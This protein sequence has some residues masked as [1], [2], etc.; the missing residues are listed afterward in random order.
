MAIVK[1]TQLHGL[2][3]KSDYTCKSS[4]MCNNTHTFT[5]SFLDGVSSLSYP[6]QL[7]REQEYLTAISDRRFDSLDQ[8]RSERGRHR[9]VHPDVTTTT[10]NHPRKTV[11]R[12]L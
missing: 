7:N 12:L 4:R 11:P 3:D 10:R 9:F 1:C 5:N 6:T 2:A 8:Y